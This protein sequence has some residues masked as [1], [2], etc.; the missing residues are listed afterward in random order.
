MQRVPA[1]CARST[2]KISLQGLARLR[3]A[4]TAT[5]SPGRPRILVLGTGWGSYSFLHTIDTKKYDVTVVSPRDHM[6]FTPLLASTTV[7]TLEHRSIIEPVRIE[8]SKRK[9]EFIQADATALNLQDKT[10]RC[11]SS[12][13]PKA[14]CTHEFEMP[15]DYLVVGIGAVPNTFGIPGVR[16]NTMFLKQANDARQIRRRIHD[17][18]EVASIPGQSNK[19]IEELLTFTVVGGGP[20]GVEFAA[21]LTDMLAEDAHRLYPH[22]AH[23]TKVVLVNATND[24]LSSFDVSLREYALRRLKRQ[25]CDVRLGVT[26][27]KVTPNSVEL[28]NGETIQTNLVV[29][30]AGVGPH[31]L[32]QNLPDVHCDT[33]HGHL[34]VD[35]NLRIQAADNAFAIGDCAEIEGQPLPAIA[36]V[37]E[38]Q[39]QYL[40][41]RFN[42]G[43]GATQDNDP[44][45]FASKGALAYLGRYGAVAK[46]QLGDDKPKNVWDPTVRV[47]GIYA[48]FVW[49]TVY[50][51]K[52][53]YWRNRLQV[54][55]DWMKTFIFGRDG[56]KF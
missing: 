42:E 33:R 25:R 49:R 15:Y 35:D 16:E 8:A 14:A 13:L 37:A 36:Q 44:F 23:K 51:T 46:I 54:P 41:R 28:G 38:Q 26:V 12:I 55:M 43:M 3:F 20:T 29:W 11:V 50:L 22:V 53:G 7:G 32:V 19:A 9:F 48:W 56:S 1:L 17:N 2:L 6:L 47:A 39:A 52:L 5:I 30:S 45:K 27:N 21:E 4:S 24:V 10:V 34:L 40:A 31:P 18:F